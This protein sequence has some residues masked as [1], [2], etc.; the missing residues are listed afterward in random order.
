ML[1]ITSGHF[2]TSYNVVHVN[3]LYITANKICKSR[4]NKHGVCIITSSNNIVL[5]IDCNYYIRHSRLIRLFAM[6]RPIICRVQ[7]DRPI[8]CCVNQHVDT[9]FFWLS[10]IIHFIDDAVKTKLIQLIQEHIVPDFF[11]FSQVDGCG[12]NSFDFPIYMHFMLV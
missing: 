11:F 1:S 2:N 6:D 5:A 10:T 4:L 3:V 7:L 12:K 9:P 8:V